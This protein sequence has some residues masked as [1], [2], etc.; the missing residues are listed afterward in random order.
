MITDEYEL[1]ER[2]EDLRRDTLPEIWTKVI[3]SDGDLVDRLVCTL[4][5]IKKF[6][7]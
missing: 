7:W 1:K 6:P 3:G 4:Y 2:L 5:D